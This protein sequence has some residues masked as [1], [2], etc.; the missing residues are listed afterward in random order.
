MAEPLPSVFP[1]FPL[2]GVLLL[3]SSFLPLHIFEPRYRAMVEDVA[4]EDRVIGMIQPLAP[5]QDNTPRPGDEGQRPDLYEIGCAGRI[6]RLEP[7]TGGRF[8]IVLRGVSRF[9]VRRELELCRGY[10]RVEADCSEFSADLEEDQVEVDPLPLIAALQERRPGEV[11][12]AQLEQL[13]GHTVVNGLAAALPFS[14]AEKQALLEA[15]GPLARRD[16]LTS[17]IAMVGERSSPDSDG[18]VH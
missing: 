2:T 15:D 7:Q 13:P 16:L 1:V 6:E 18:V 12:L 11:D 3:P 4:E 8:V 17:L 14:P 9:R 10:R 5:R